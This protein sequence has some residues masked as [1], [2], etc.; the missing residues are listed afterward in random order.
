MNAAGV[1][2]LRKRIAAGEDEPVVMLNLLR[3]RPDGGRRRYAEYTDAV[4]PLLQQVGAKVIY[5][6]DPAPALLGAESW[7]SVLMVEYPSRL[8]FLSM[9]GSDAYREIEHLRTE[10]LASGELHPMETK[11]GGGDA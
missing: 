5:W 6:G 10:A 4:R 7:D 2:D 9:V 11:S 8:A 3:F 1:S